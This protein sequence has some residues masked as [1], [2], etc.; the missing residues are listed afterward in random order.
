MAAIV[1]IDALVL[2][3]KATDTKW[4]PL[5]ERN[6]FSISISVDTAEH[7][8]FVKSLADAWANKRRTWMSW[9]GSASGYHDDED[10]TIFDHVVA[11]EELQVRFYD[12]RQG[13]ELNVTTGLPT[14]AAGA[15]IGYWEGN[16]VLTSVEHGTGTSDFSTLNVNFDGNGPLTR[17]NAVEA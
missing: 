10:S 11:G 9:S 3:K 7:K 17:V 6:E 16:V 8:V 1:G 4:E 5:P 15:T 14:P 12:T 13:V 2:F